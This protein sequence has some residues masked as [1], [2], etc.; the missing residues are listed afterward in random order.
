[1]YQAN[2]DIAAMK[3]ADCQW[4]VCVIAMETLVRDMARNLLYTSS[5]MHQHF[6]A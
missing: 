5:A 2:K 6:E 3:G 4:A 1:M